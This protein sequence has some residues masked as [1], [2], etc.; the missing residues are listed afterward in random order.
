[1]A[2]PIRLQGLS[3][4]PRN[5]LRA[6]LD[7]APVEHS[8]A[9]LESY[10]VLQALH[11][12]GILAAIKG[13]LGASDTVIE[14]VVDFVKTPESIRTIRNL[15]LLVKLL[16]N[17]EP[18]LLSGVLGAVPGALEKGGEKDTNPPSLISLAQRFANKESRRGM[19]VAA[20]VLEAVGRSVGSGRKGDTKA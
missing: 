5:E 12:R 6:R 16:G 10:E 7:A 2:A 9:L 17:I 4:D 8:E 15:L 3:Y 18:E 19:A 20:E 13:A 1:M 11:D 14:S